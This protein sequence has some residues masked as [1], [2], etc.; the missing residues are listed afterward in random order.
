MRNTFEAAPAPARCD[1]WRFPIP[2]RGNE[3]DND[4]GRIAWLLPGFRSP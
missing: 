3:W 4:D 2:M 1:G